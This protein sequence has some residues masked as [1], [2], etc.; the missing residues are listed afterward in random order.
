[1]EE[2]Y[3][4]GKIIMVQKLIRGFLARKRLKKCNESAIK[5]QSIYR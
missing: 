1:M 4:L 2:E 5:I 3:D